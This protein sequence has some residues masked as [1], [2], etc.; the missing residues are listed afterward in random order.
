[1]RRC[2]S[3]ENS[4]SRTMISNHSGHAMKKDK[5]QQSVEQSEVGLPPEELIR[6]VRGN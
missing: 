3:A 2:A 1:M 5:S 6:R 4:F